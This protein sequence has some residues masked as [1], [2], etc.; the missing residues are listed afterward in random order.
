MTTPLLTDFTLQ[1][2]NSGVLL[3][4]APTDFYTPIIDVVKVTGLD[5]APFRTSTKA[6]D[7]RDGGIVEAEFLN[8]RTIVITGNIYGQGNNPIGPYLDALKANY[9]P[10]KVDTPLYIKEPGNAQRQVFCKSLGF[11]YDWDQTYRTNSTAYQITLAAADP[12]VYGTITRQSNGTSASGSFPGTGFNIGF[13]MGFGGPY[14]PAS[15]I[16]VNQGNKTVGGYI[17]VTGSGTNVRIVNN[18]TG[19]VLSTNLTISTSDTLIFDLYQRRVTLN[20]VS[21]RGSVTAEN[22]FQ[23]P[24]GQTVLQMQVDSGSISASSL[25]Y[26]GWQ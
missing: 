22:W 10:S 5:S 8:V 4:N 24:P 14:V 7:G 3:N 1:F 13:N 16:V 6:L 2:G 19:K 17:T 20:G 11:K 23:F 12:V 25:N 18:N 21:R 9:A 15:L 26:D